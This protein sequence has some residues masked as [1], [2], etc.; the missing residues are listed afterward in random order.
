[1]TD[2]IVRRHFE[3]DCMITLQSTNRRSI[4]FAAIVILL[5]VLGNAAPKQPR[6]VVAPPAPI[7]S[8]PASFGFI[9]LTKTTPSAHASSMTALPDGSLLVAWFGGEREGASDVAIQMARVR[10]GLV[11]DQW[12]S[13]TRGRLEELTHRVIR[14]L[15]NPVVWIDSAQ[16]VHMHVVSVSYGGWSGSSVNQLASDD[17]GRTW[18]DARRLILSPLFNFSTLVRNQIV[19]MDDGTY[20]LPAYHEFLNKNGLWVSVREDGRVVRSQRMQ[21]YEGNWLQP[22]VAPT[23]AT[24]AIAVLRSG[25]QYEPVIGCN[26]TQNAGETWPRRKS[27]DIANPNASIAMMRLA[28]GRLLMAANPIATGRNVL[29][30]FVSTDG[31]AEWLPSRTIERDANGVEFS[32]PFLAQTADGTVHLSYT[33]K[34][35]GIRLC[36]FSVAWLNTGDNAI[37]AVENAP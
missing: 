18:T 37:A 22:A 1:M 6:F 25:N 9:D 20:G 14:M 11:E 16:R 8:A 28:D 30:L 35:K 33:W 15:G 24:E 27:L 23:S 2:A 5:A 31:G 13:L 34:R 29:Q 32:Y 4:S 3:P 19:P 10:G 7:S 26:S 17:G 36:S 21:L 12:V